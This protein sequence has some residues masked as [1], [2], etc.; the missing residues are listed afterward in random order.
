[1]AFTSSYTDGLIQQSEYYYGTPEMTPGLSGSFSGSFQ[2]DGSSLTGISS[3]PFP[4]TGDAVITGSLTISGSAT[5]GLTI[6]GPIQVNH[7]G[8][9]SAVFTANSDTNEQVL[10][11]D[12]KIAIEDSNQELAILSANEYGTR[13][14]ILKLAEWTS[15]IVGASLTAGAYRNFLKGQLV[16]GR[17]HTAGNTVH[18]HTLDVTGSAVI[19]GSLLVSGSGVSGSF[20]GSFEGDGSG[21]TGIS[22]TPFPF[23]G[24]AEI[25]GSLSVSGSGISFIASGGTV[26]SINNTGSFT[27]GEGATA[28]NDTAVAI[29]KSA[30]ATSNG[31]SIGGNSNASL[32]NTV[33]IGGYS[34]VTGQTGIALG[35]D[36]DVSGYSAIGIGAYINNSAGRSIVFNAT[37]ENAVN[38]SKAS[39]SA[40]YMTSKTIPDFEFVAGGT[41]TLANSNLSGSAT[42]TA[43][44]GT[45]LGDGS[46][47]TNLP[48]AS[49]GKFGIANASGSYTYYS[50]LSSSLQAANSGDVIELF[51]SVTESSDHIYHLKDG[52]DFNFNGNELF[53][54]ASAALDGKDI[55]DD[56]NVAVS[57]SFYNGSIRFTQ[58]TSAGIFNRLL[59]LQADGTEIIN[60]GF[61]WKPEAGVNAS[62][63]Y[64]IEVDGD[65]TINGGRFVGKNLNSYMIKLWYG[66][67]KN[68]EVINNGSCI[69]MY[70]SQVNNCKVE[71]TGLTTYCI[72][73]AGTTSTVRNS[74]VRIIDGDDSADCIGI[75][76]N[77]VL[78]CT[79]E[80]EGGGGIDSAY[81]TVNCTVRNSNGIGITAGGDVIGGSVR[82]T[83][84]V[85]LAV[86]N[87]EVMGTSIY[88]KDYLGPGVTISGG[89]LL[90]CS[91]VDD[92]PATGQK[93]V[94]VNTGQSGASIVN[95]SFLFLQSATNQY[96]ITAEDDD[97]TVYFANN[98]FIKCVPF[99]PT[100]VTQGILNTPD[101]QGNVSVTY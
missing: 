4:F 14:G 95:C 28:A 87:N 68:A 72:G 97:T 5:P 20:S 92:Y 3:T 30:N 67:L 48:A 65:A 79:V 10:I 19:T 35:Y 6:E 96:A 84:N 22:S 90:G 88:N 7:S 53:Y 1:M 18:G 54:S 66:E 16:V 11:Y 89:E 27:L 77:Y 37:G 85:S 101:A 34:S 15:G 56:N 21:L 69:Y 40:F 43:S 24:D 57:C 52:V 49:T 8:S 38:H 44:F 86:G 100:K 55:F 2:G 41:S 17:S 75:R 29:G 47:L 39:A 99:N 76:A 23:T 45:Y 32:G 70:Q 50:D 25:T 78:G 13:F 74:Y 33:S 46:Q 83:N 12:S 93:S 59:Y 60:N 94:Q 26:F 51:T 36:A 98:T 9:P 61:T 81:E 82:T 80:V 42:S 31:V 63:Y 62:P 71:G 91:I 58:G 73:N 64:T